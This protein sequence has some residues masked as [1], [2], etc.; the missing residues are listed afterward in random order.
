MV[1]PYMHDRFTMNITPRDIVPMN[2]IFLVLLL[3]SSFTYAEKD[4]IEC[5]VNI[6]DPKTGS[7]YKVVSSYPDYGEQIRI[8]FTLPSRAY[9]DCSFVYYRKYKG[10]VLSCDFDK[11]DSFYVISDRTIDD[12]GV[13]NDMPRKNSLFIKYKDIH[14]DINGIC[15]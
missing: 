14:F 9:N 7:K 11:T 1:L 15:K 8:P 12:K 2:R 6:L 3:L 5:S 13:S 4:A 10:T